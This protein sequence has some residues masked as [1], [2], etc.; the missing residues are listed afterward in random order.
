ML[1]YT[2]SIHIFGVPAYL[3]L[4]SLLLEQWQPWQKRSGLRAK[5]VS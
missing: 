1:V 3:E 5:P 2:S 4:K